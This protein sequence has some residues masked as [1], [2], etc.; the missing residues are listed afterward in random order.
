MVIYLVTNKINGKKYI[1]QTKRNPND[2]WNEHVGE[3]MRKPGEKTCALHYAI[4]KHGVEAFIFEVIQECSS[5]EDLN[6]SE[7][8]YIRVFNTLLPVGY[9][10]TIGGDSC[11]E[12]LPATK[13]KIGASVSKTFAE[14]PESREKCSIAT[15]SRIVSPE[16][17]KKRSVN[18]T[19]EKN[20]MWGKKGDLASGCIKKSSKRLETITIPFCQYS[21]DGKLLAVYSSCPLAKQTGYDP[22]IIWGMIS[23]N[24]RKY[25]EYENLGWLI[26]F[27]QKNNVI[28]L[29]HWKRYNA[30]VTTGFVRRLLLKNGYEIWC[31]FANDKLGLNLR[32][33]NNVSKKQVI[34]SVDK[35]NKHHN[36]IWKKIDKIEF[37]KIVLENNVPAYIYDYQK[38]KFDAL[39]QSVSLKN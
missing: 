29:S 3:A 13:A 4:K 31:D 36:F 16:E 12:V 37:E 1:G 30:P 21:L 24:R 33:Q 38:V 22:D 11:F 17:L 6:D 32:K 20:P 34:T 35:I 2:R 8:T 27:C 26:S 14:R 7:R 18:N 9:N 15:K 19:K 25:Q 39:R 28:W 23:G 5:R 10:M